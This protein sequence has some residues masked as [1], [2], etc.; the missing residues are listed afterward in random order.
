MYPVGVKRQNFKNNEK[1]KQLSELLIDLND[2]IELGYTHIMVKEYILHDIVQTNEDWE[3]SPE[4]ERDGYFC[5]DQNE[6]CIRIVQ[7]HWK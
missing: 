4:D 1:F 3:A 2:Y 7:K 5:Y 6:D